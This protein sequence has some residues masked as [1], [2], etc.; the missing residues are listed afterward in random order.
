MVESDI[1]AV[2]RIGARGFRS[3]WGAELL[4]CGNVIF[5]LALVVDAPH[6][7]K[8]SKRRNT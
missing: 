1:M 8:P 3:T 6:F 5:S 2:A 7:P 4:V